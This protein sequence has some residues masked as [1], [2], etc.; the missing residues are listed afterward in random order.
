MKPIFDWRYVLKTNTQFDYDWSYRNSYIEDGVIDSRLEEQPFC[1]TEIL[2]DTSGSI[3]E[4]M[5]RN[6]IMECKNILQV[7]RL[8]IG[9]FDTKFYG[10][11]EIRTIDDLKNMDFIGR[12]GTDFNCAVNAFSFRVDNRIIFTD[13]YA[14]M[15]NKPMDIVWM[16]YGDN[17]INPKGG[18]VYYVTDDQLKKLR[19]VEREKVLKKYR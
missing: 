14:D 10:F 13:G 4:T 5:L 12:G 18:Q 16:V 11:N 3:E 2:L 19:C 17:K 6:F 7:S 8:K 15:P 1:E 9:C